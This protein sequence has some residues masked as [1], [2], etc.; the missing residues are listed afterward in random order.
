ME[1]YIFSIKFIVIILNYNNTYFI[2]FRIYVLKYII[3]LLFGIHLLNNYVN[4][5]KCWISL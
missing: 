3:F 2:H 4:I 1:V 5:K